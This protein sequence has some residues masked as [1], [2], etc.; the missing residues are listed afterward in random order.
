M[1]L[2]PTQK[3]ILV[4]LLLGDGHIEKRS[5][6]D[7]T[8][9][10]FKYTQS[11]IRSPHIAYFNHV[12]SIFFSFCSPTFSPKIKTFVTKA[13]VKGEDRT[14]SSSSFSTLTLPVFNKYKALFYNG[15]TKIV[16]A[17]IY[18][19]LTYR[20]LAYWIMD[21]GSLQNKGLHLN[22]YGF[23]DS[24]LDL[25]KTVLESKFNLK[26]SIHKHNKKKRIYIWEASLELIKPKL[27]PFVLSEM[28][29]KI[30]HTQLLLK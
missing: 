17:N 16:P 20:G 11:A 6:K 1:K 14:Y 8:G 7:G 23:S 3:E 18:T 25:L 15:T 12:Y 26:I 30:D 24:D 5:S 9:S 21:D 10:R 22:T 19:L 29:Y 2:S 13:A 4:G 27:L 28:A